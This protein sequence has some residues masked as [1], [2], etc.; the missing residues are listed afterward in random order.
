LALGWWSTCALGALAEEPLVRL[1]LDGRPLEGTPL[2]AS[3][4]NIIFLAR[5]GRLLEFPPGKAEAWS[6]QSGGFRS[7]S[8]AEIRGQLLRE[9][10]RGYDVSGVGHYLVV[11]PAGQKDQWAPRFEALYRSFVHY[12]AARGWQLAEPQFPLIAVVYARQGDF[13]RQ[14]AAEGVEVG[15]TLL[16]YYSPL[17]NRILVY[18]VTAGG[19][20]IDWTVN[21]ETIVHEAAHQAAFNTGVHSRYGVAPRWVVEGLGTMFEARG[22]SQSRAYRN[23]G[24]RINTRLL[25]SYR[26]LVAS[27][28]R[29]AGSIA[30]MIS[31]DRVFDASARLAYSEA[32]AL[33]F[34]LC[35]TE[36]R[37]YF[38]YLAKTAAA[39][40]F[41][42]PRSPERLKDFTDVF[43]ADL[44]ML[45]ARLQR[46]VKGLK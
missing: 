38:A 33:S 4:E 25:A 6:L 45:D 41:H 13:Q 7:Y 37:K 14:A 42:R 15:S 31:S 3:E 16:G 40:P 2:A 39:P 5:D 22:V 29:P 1:N 30:A 32:W 20:G 44:K 43:G 23:R 11:H 26:E 19:S 46:Y 35:E 27:G 12:F 17:T 28:D 10:G 24:D 9:F 34:F 36:P 18:D 21:A 8:Q